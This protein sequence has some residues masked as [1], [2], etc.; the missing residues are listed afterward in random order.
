MYRY[1][2][3]FTRAV[4]YR[5][6]RI[7]SCKSCLA[8]VFAVGA[9]GA[10]AAGFG[11]ETCKFGDSELL[12]GDPFSVTGFDGGDGTGNS[13]RTESDGCGSSMRT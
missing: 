10:G 8:V 9:R 13:G 1:R 4:V 5:I 7:L 6:G 12:L 2:S 3:K 11:L